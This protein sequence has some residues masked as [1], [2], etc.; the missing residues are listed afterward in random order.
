MKIIICG[1]GL[2][3]EGIAKQL[4]KEDNDITVIGD[5]L[6]DLNKIS[7]EIDISTKFGF[8]SHPDVLQDAGLKDAQMIIA[9]T[10]SD[11]LN[12]IICEMAYCLSNTKIKIARINSKAYL[13]PEWQ[14][15]Y[16]KNKIPIDYIISPEREVAEAIINRLQISGAINTLPFGKNKVKVIEVKCAEDFAFHKKTVRE[17]HRHMLR[18]QFSILAIYRNQQLIFCDD[19]TLI[20]AGDELFFIAEVENI[21]KIMN[22]FGYSPT[23]RRS[24]IIIGGGNIGLHIAQALENQ[25]VNINLKI[26]EYNQ[27]RAEEI[28]DSLSQTTVLKGSGLDNQILEEA[29]IQGANTV[30]A[31]TN[32]DEVNILSSILAKKLGAESCFTLVNSMSSYET[33]VSSLDID[34]LINPRDMT[35]SK[36]LQ[37][38]R[39]GK[40]ISAFSICG[41]IAEIIELQVTNKSSFS[42]R[43]ISDLELPSGIRICIIFREDLTIFPDSTTQILENDVLVVLAQVNLLSKLDD[44]LEKDDVFF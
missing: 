27:K 15:I 43:I 8:P 7:A 32:D 14:F 39:R 40:I 28:A 42:D 16:A 29:G 18:P 4:S 5:N 17:V 22:L 13:K 9:V 36:I 38:T 33:I 31:V 20:Q 34:V 12:M 37:H 44:M 41:G 2:V 10:A 24:V 26:I 35:I 25:P 21:T 30:I 23:D 19:S 11:E 3:A 1:S 6:D